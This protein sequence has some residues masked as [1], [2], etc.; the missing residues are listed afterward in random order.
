MAEPSRALRALSFGSVADDY[1]RFRPG[2]SAD[3]LQWLLPDGA[4][5]VVDMGAGTGALTRLLVERVADVTAVEPDPQMRR[6]LA[7]RAPRAT[8]VAGSAEALP[9]ADGSQDA[10]V[11]A[12]MWHWV[13]PQRAVPEIARVLRPGGRLGVLWTHA[14][15]RVPWVAELWDRLRAGH[16]PRPR[17]ERIPE[18]PVGL[19]LGPVEGPY[20]ATYLRAM[21]RDDLIGV[22]GTYSGSIVLDE[23]ERRARLDALARSLDADERF[24]DGAAIDVPIRTM[25]WRATRS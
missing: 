23:D 25:A 14:D 16:A 2:P 24:A 22:S 18:V 19:G 17:G 10:V 12:S 4:A 11:G 7:L 5:H 3:V 1:D 6:V 13:D 8:I 9:V 15:R 21:T 20:D